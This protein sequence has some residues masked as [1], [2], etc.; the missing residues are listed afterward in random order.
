[1]QFQRA[2]A[3][4]LSQRDAD[5]IK[6]RYLFSINFAL[7]NKDSEIAPYIALAEVYDANIKYLDTINKSMTPKVAKS[8]YGMMLSKF[9]DQRK[10]TES[11]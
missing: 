8:K 4:D 3:A 11:Q 9:V 10:K 7:N 5:N 6:R 2:T 1:M